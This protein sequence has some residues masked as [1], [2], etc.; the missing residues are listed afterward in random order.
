VL[1]AHLGPDFG[2]PAEGVPKFKTRFLDFIGSDGGLRFAAKRGWLNG[3]ECENEA[4]ACVYRVVTGVSRYL[5]TPLHSST[6][7]KTGFL[8][9][10]SSV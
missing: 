9:L 2:A 3:N 10:G 6:D 4:S 7:A 1:G 5:F 8:A